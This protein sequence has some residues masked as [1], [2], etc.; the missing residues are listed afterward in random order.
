MATSALAVFRQLKAAFLSQQ[1]CLL[2][3]QSS[4]K[5]I[6]RYCTDDL[7]LFNLESCHYNLLNR[8]NVLRH[9]EP[10]RYQKLLALAPYQWPISTL[11]SQLKFGDQ[12][13]NSKALGDLFRWHCLANTQADSMTNDTLVI[14]VPL[15]GSRLRSRKYNQSLE[16][17]RHLGV[18]KQRWKREVCR[19]TRRT[20]AQ[21]DLSAKQRRANVNNAFKVVGRLDTNHVII[22]D[23]VV[24]TG[25]TV[26]S[27]CKT[28][29]AANPNLN[30][31]VWCIAVTLGY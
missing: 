22:V 30:I 29:L 25:A 26:N 17:I 6:C 9:L 1:Q 7:E 21:T 12:L 11:I 2:C 5:L 3:H 15:H 31:E 13:I 4:N 14:P 24:T 19:R 23:D 18:N 8:S 20:D 10:P 16:I 28:L 27:L